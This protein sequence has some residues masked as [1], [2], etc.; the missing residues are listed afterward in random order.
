MWSMQRDQMTVIRDGG[1]GA[2]LTVLFYFYVMKKGRRFSAAL[3]VQRLTN[4][5]HT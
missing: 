5:S 3:I 1:K 4:T 2:Q